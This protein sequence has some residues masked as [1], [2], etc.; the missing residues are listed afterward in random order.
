MENTDV[1]DMVHNYATKIQGYIDLH[2]LI[3]TMNLILSWFSQYWFL[4]KE[5][6]LGTSTFD[7]KKF[8]C[9]LC[10][11]PFRTLLYL[12]NLFCNLCRLWNLFPQQTGD[13]I[14]I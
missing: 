14:H 12:L 7:V 13:T 11:S 8:S 1:G 10:L 9:L 3:R 5:L 6:L 2:A 4:D